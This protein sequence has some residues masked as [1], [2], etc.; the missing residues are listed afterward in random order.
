MFH[1]N[2]ELTRPKACH[3]APFFTSS[4]LPWNFKKGIVVDCSITSFRI[5]EHNIS[6]LN[7]FVD[8]YLSFLEVDM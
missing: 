5:F 6:I 3:P 4:L 1:L 7:I 2:I 8:Y